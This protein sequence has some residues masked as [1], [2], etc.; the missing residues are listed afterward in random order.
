MNPRDPEVRKSGNFGCFLLLAP[1]III[2]ARNRQRTRKMSDMSVRTVKVPRTRTSGFGIRL[3]RSALCKA[4]ERISAGSLAI[5]DGEETFQFGNPLSEGEPHAVIEINDPATWRQMLLGG[6]LGTGESYMQGHWSTPDLP[7]V[8]RLF[9]ANLDALESTSAGNSWIR[10]LPLVIAHAMNSN[11]RRGSRRNISA[12]YDLGNEFFKLFLDKSMMY[13]SAVFPEPG[14]SLEQASEHKL[15]LICKQLQLKPEDHLLEIGTGWGGMAVHA[16]RE[17][18]C[19]VTTTTISREQYQYTHDRVQREGLQDRITL[20]REDYR[21]LKGR[22]DKLVS[23]EMI[24]AVGHQF[25]GKYF[26]Q[27]SKLLKPR[28]LMA[29]QAIIVADRRYER[30]RDRVDFIKRHIFPGGCLPS[31]EVIARHLRRDTD[32]QMINLR[33]ITADYAKTLAQWRTR[34]LNRLEAVREQGFDA[35]FERMWE[36]YLAYCEGGFSERVISAVQLT[37]AKPGYRVG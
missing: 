4:L 22:F 7:Q 2:E 24:E 5:H 11:T 28:G 27:C 35:A 34:F 29:L 33:D 20:L 3:A 12:H 32:M 15:D 37:L 6:G 26:S 30:A 17:Y 18:G 14:T 1:W 25:F 13:S 16:A 23:I 9:A 21:Q 10:R 19:R 31:L 36:F 8:I